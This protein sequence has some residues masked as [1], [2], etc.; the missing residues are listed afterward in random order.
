[1]KTAKLGVTGFSI[2]ASCNIPGR[3]SFSALDLVPKQNDLLSPDISIDTLPPTIL[4]V[5]TGRTAGT[6][7]YKDI[8]NIVVE[9]SKPVY[10]SELPSKFDTAFI[11]AN[12]SYMIPAGLPYLELN[13]QA[14]ALMQ[15]YE[16]SGPGID[17]RKLSFVYVVGTG[18]YTPA[19]GQL[20]VPAG[21]TIQL[22]AGVIVSVATG[23][24]ADLTSMPLP[25]REGTSPHMKTSISTYQE[26]ISH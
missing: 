16:G 20:E 15:G 18:E 1:M 7:T 8:I 3:V 12:A 10:F 9:F 6:Y 4:N 5:Y 23:L 25:G 26:S 21:G 24:E 11:K 17:R 14:F 22:N 19:R 13:S 2:P